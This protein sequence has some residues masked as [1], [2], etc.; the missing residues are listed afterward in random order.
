MTKVTSLFSRST[1][2]MIF[3]MVLTVLPVLANNFRTQLEDVRQLQHLKWRVSFQFET[4]I[5]IT[6]CMLIKIGMLLVVFLYDDIPVALAI[7]FGAQSLKA[8]VVKVA[9]SIWL[10]LSVLH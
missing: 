9:V 7:N 5:R 3:G 1:A 2:T 4:C 6:N 10:S 8:A